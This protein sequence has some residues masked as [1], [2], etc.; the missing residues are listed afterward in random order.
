MDFPK[1][2][3]RFIGKAPGL[4]EYSKCNCVLAYLGQ[5]NFYPDP[6]ERYHENDPISLCNQ[7]CKEYDEID[8]FP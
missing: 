2:G 1:A 6:D 4:L 8:P 3:K 7:C 5:K